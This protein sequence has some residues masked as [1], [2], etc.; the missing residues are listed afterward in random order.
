M[1]LTR[2]TKVPKSWAFFAQLIIILSIYGQFVVNA[3]FILLIKKYID[4]PAAIMGLISLQIYVTFLIGPMVAWAS[5][6]IWTRFGRRKPFVASA[7][8]LRA[9]CLLAMPFAPNLWVL[10]LFRWLYDFFVD[11]AAPAQGLVYEIVPAKQRGLSAGFMKAFMDIGNLVFFTLLLG[12]FHDAYFMG[13]FQFFATPSGGTLMFIL[14]ALVFLGAAIFEAIGIKEI[15]PP[16]RKRLMDGR[17]PGENLLRHFIRSVFQDVLAKDLAPLYLLL[18]A[19]IMFGFALG[20]FQPLLFTEQWGYKLQTFGN[21]I[22]IGVPLGIALGLLGGW[23]ADRYGKMRIVFWS[24]IGNLIVNIAYTVFVYYQPDYRP[25]FWEIVAFGNLAYVFGAVKSVA[26]GPLLWEYVARNRMGS[27]SAGIVVFNS[28]FRNSVGV[29]VGAWLLVWSIWF[30]PQAGYNVTATFA[31]PLGR[32]EVLKRTAEADIDTAALYLRPVHQYGVDGTE[33]RRWWIHREDKRAQELIKEREN[34]QNKLGSLE[35]KKESFFTG[36]ERKAEIEAEMAQARE[37]IREI[38]RELE[39]RSR[40]LEAR[41]APVLAEV[42][43]PP[44]GQLL[45]ADLRDERLTLELRT[46]EA[47]PAEQVEIVEKNLQGHEFR[48]VL[49][50][51]AKG[52]PRRMP[53]LKVTSIEAPGSPPHGVRLEAKVDP[54]FVEF[55]TAVHAAGLRSDAAFELASGVLASAASQ[56]TARDADYALSEANFVGDDGAG[57]RIRFVIDP[58]ASGGGEP[59]G[60]SAIAELFAGA[61]RWIAAAEA[62]FADGTY[63]A[64]LELV[65]EARGG[66]DGRLPFDEVRPRMEA[67][68][69]GEAADAALAMAV[70]RKLAET[71]AARPIYVTVPRHDVESGYIEREYEYFFSSQILQIGTDV[72]G[73]GILLL[74]IWL[75]KRG[76]LQRYG[77]EEDM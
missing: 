52:I 50:E 1:L 54:R 14:C 4:N 77:A 49:R 39:A 58:E 64:E 20:V 2:K 13:P 29:L 5:D 32:E 42:R 8:F 9:V 60:A 69:D 27:A 36:E 7:D 16:G 30:F 72:F 12:R 66:A 21:T 37:R 63:R 24:T 51:D 28:V 76:T 57:R 41:L 26:I 68:L 15:Y 3:P 25:S 53:E 62:D 44:G 48:T 70:L 18:F 46:I 17:K 43:F 34:L 38:E 74:I 75:E 45:A 23:M 40:E 22:A 19:N 71:L 55:F 47:L 10:V 61:S 65:E 11:L 35:G 6:R 73:I 67:A 59:P 31:E 56:F 33:S